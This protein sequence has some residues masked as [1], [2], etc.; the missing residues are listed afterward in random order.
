MPRMARRRRSSRSAVA[1][2]PPTAMAAS[3]TPS[4]PRDVVGTTAYRPARARA[5]MAP[6]VSDLVR[7]SSSA[8]TDAGS[9]NF[10][11]GQM[12]STSSSKGKPTRTTR[13]R[14]FV[15]TTIP[16]SPGEEPLRATERDAEA[17]PVVFDPSLPTPQEVPL[18]LLVR[19]PGDLV[20]EFD[21]AGHHKERKL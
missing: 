21:E 8:T 3:I 9:S 18:G 2:Q 14:T 16:G 4:S 19:G 11:P 1:T 13:K 10:A 7:P 17:F 12:R 20:D 15:S 6:G 5:A